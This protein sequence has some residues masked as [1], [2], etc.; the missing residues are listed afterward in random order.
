M[1]APP[2]GWYASPIAAGMLRWWDGLRWADVERPTVE[3]APVTP[4]PWLPEPISVV[5]ARDA[6]S[7]AHRPRTVDVLTRRPSI[8]GRSAAP[9]LIRGTLDPHPEPVGP[10]VDAP[11]APAVHLVSG[12][13]LAGLAGVVSALPM[14]G[15]GSI[16]LLV[17]LVGFVPEWEATRAG[18]GETSTHGVVVD[19][20]ETI[21]SDGRSC[22]PEASF[23]VDGSLYRARAGFRSSGCPAVGSATTVIYTTAT[24]WDGT[25]RLPEP[26]GWLLLMAIFPVIGVGLVVGGLVAGG[27]GLVALVSGR[28][29]ERG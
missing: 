21:S 12:R 25:A 1:S 13:I 27:K 10:I 20:H 17:G 14:L 23:A 19:Q 4:E 28:R 24:P 26:A 15:I 11:I 9:D 2:P 22:S 6:A 3:D 8:R 7:A 29:P 16:F 18:A 5:R